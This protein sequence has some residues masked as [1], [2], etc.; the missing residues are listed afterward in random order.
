MRDVWR[1]ANLCARIVAV[2][3]VGMIRGSEAGGEIESGDSKDGDV[4]VEG[5]SLETG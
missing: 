4:L 5:D 3:V 1:A 2:E